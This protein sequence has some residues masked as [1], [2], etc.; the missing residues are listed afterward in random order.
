M[1]L[2]NIY[3]LKIKY[4]YKIDNFTHHSKLNFQKEQQ[5]ELDLVGV[6]S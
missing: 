1:K 5:F 3:K 2:H 4:I 6:T